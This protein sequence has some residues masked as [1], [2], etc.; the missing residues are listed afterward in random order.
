MDILNTN[1]SIV[2]NI[3]QNIFNEMQNGS[4]P[5]N[6]CCCEQCRLDTT[7]YTLNR[8][9]PHYVVSNRGI[10]R[11][12]QESIKRQ[13]MEADITNLVYNGLR[14]VKHNQRQTA[15][16]DDSAFLTKGLINKPVF[17]IPTIVGR[18]FDGKSFAPITGIKVEL[19]SDNKPVEMRN[20]NWQNPYIMFSNTPGT[21][22]FWP[23]PVIAEGPEINRVFKYSIKTEAAD[24]DE[25]THFFSIPVVS[26]IF[27]AFSFSANS[28]F[29]LPDLYMFPPGEAEQNE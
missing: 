15:P 21:F 23:A 17:D 14:L 20:H 5:E 12:G 24:Y 18:I 28:T 10:T 13:Q 3:V 27:S 19:W 6:F 1:E 11:L 22:T 16:H 26:K 29:K 7:C 25:F 8:I 2:F 9:E 4:N